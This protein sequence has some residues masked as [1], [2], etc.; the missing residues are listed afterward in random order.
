MNAGELPFRKEALD[1]RRSAMPPEARSQR[2]RPVLALAS[3]AVCLIALAWIGMVPAATCR[4][5]LGSHPVRLARYL[6]MPGGQA[7]TCAPRP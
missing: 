1:H 6:F 2:P 5:S 3:A 4:D 7:T